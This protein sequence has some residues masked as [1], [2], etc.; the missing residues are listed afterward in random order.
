VA[1][2]SATQ[3]NAAVN[4][5]GGRPA[6]LRDHVPELDGLRGIAILSVVLYHCEQRLTHPALHAVVQWGWAGVNLFF[7]LSG[8]LITGIIL[9]S[10]DDPHFFRNFYARRSL[11][12]WPVYVLL[13]LLVYTLVP[14]Y[15]SGYR[16]AWMQTIG[17]PWP[18]L[19]LFVQNL[20]VLALPG[21]IGPTWSLAIEEQFYVVWAPFARFIRNRELIIA[22]M[23]AIAAS[24]FLR[25]WNHGAFTPTHTL[26]HLDGLA[27]GSLIAVSLRTLAWSAATFRKI[28]IAAIVLASPL[29]VYLLYGG[30]PFSDS[31]LAMVF[32]GMLLLALTTSDKRTL[33]SRALASRP[34]RFYGRISYGLYMIH[35]L[36]FA[37]IGAFDL[38][39]NR[40]GVIG[41]LAIVSVR[42][43]LATLVAFAMWH[44][45]EKPILRLKRYF[46]AKPEAAAIHVE[47]VAIAAVD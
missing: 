17:A 41:D 15:A 18:Y 4:V 6:W 35:I 44:L 20:F 42:I 25:A 12:I 37:L 2:L 45:F 34:L 11:R 46:H 32:A 19:L 29:L 43:T 22:L 26:I 39:M 23:I 21:T 14:A 38:T 30:S 1:T 10:R 28:A 47:D 40:Y 27:F 33:Y 31:L 36:V 5:S 8:F 7:V 16:W 3:G 24:P 9:D 13:L